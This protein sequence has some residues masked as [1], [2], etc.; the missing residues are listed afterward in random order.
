[1]SK[2]SE[3]CDKPDCPLKVNKCLKAHS[4]LDWHP[5]KDIYMRYPGKWDVKHREHVCQQENLAFPLTVD[6]AKKQLSYYLVS[7]LENELE[8]HLQLFARDQPTGV[9]RWEHSA[10]PAQCDSSVREELEQLRIEY[11]EKARLIRERPRRQL[12][13]LTEAEGLRLEI[14]DLANRLNDFHSR[15]KPWFKDD[16]QRVKFIFD[17]DH[18]VCGAQ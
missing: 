10:V 1:M 17:G 16:D 4:A 3:I 11:E 9:D 13:L 8:Q 5:T 2:K 15:C 7:K 14:A 12:E 18:H 6:D